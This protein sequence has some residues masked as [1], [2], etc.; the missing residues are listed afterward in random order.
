MH[1]TP[2]DPGHGVPVTLLRIVA[3]NIVARNSGD[4]VSWDL[5][6]LWPMH[7]LVRNEFSLKLRRAQRRTSLLYLDSCRLTGRSTV[8]SSL[9]CTHSFSLSLL[10]QT[11]NVYRSLFWPKD[12]PATGASTKIEYRCSMSA[13]TSRL[14]ETF[15]EDFPARDDPHRTIH[16][17][18]RTQE[19]WVAC[20]PSSLAILT[21][22]SP[23]LLHAGE[24]VLSCIPVNDTPC[25]Y[26][27][28]SARLFLRIRCRVHQLALCSS[29]CG[30]AVL[31]PLLSS[32]FHGLVY[33]ERR[34]GI[35]NTWVVMHF[36]FSAVG[37]MY[38]YQG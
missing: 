25:R 7:K 14:F 19:T 9:S 15:H 10:F 5:E 12:M 32:L 1:N 29:N 28:F 8:D 24:R 18:R 33:L 11:L 3:I 16:M 13:S 31:C 21:H 36:C 20:R 38:F 26:P 23:P 37:K 22:A 17:V 34:S 2:V 30:Y 6:I 27:S 4:E 35:T